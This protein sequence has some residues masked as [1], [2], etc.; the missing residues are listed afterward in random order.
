M[1]NGQQKSNLI[2]INQFIIDNLILVIN[3]QIK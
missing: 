3:N 2:I 1:I